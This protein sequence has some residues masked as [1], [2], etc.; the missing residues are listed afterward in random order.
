[1]A[2]CHYFS[3]ILAFASDFRFFELFKRGFSL[4]ES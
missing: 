2:R 1:M 4:V 3:E